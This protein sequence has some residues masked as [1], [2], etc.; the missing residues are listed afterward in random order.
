MATSN[1]RRTTADDLLKE[2]ARPDVPAISGSNAEPRR[3]RSD[4]ER[5]TAARVALSSTAEERQASG[6][7]IKEVVAPLGLG[8]AVEIATLAVLALAA[9][10]AHASIASWVGVGA[11]AMTIGLLY[12]TA[13]I[14]KGATK[15]AIDNLTH[16][17]QQ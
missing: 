10:R 7:L 1:A 2:A 13:V 4:Y 5:R 11:V 8:I 3:R 17:L 9:D 16:G 6:S 12:W 14:L 15:P